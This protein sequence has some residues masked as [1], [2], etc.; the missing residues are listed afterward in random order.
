[1]LYIVCLQATVDPM[2]QQL[3]PAKE[4]PQKI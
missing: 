3:I 2:K 1:L 4:G